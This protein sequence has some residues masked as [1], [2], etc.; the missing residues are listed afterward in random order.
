MT[1]SLIAVGLACT[2]ASPVASQEIVG[3]D[4]SSF[5]ISEAV[6]Q[7]G[8]VRIA[9]PNGF[10]RVS[11]GSGTRVEIR[12]EKDVRRGSVTDVG[13]VVRREGNG[14][15]V[16]AVYEGVDECDE[17]GSYRGTSASRASSHNRQ[18]R[19][20]FTVQMPSGSRVRASTGNG[21][22]QVTGGGPEVIAASGNGAITVSGAA[23]E[24][25]ASSGNGKVT[26][27][28]AGGPVEV[29]SGNGDIRVNTILGPVSANSGNGTIEV[30][31]DRLT[32]SPDMKFSTGNGRIILSVPDD[33][34]AE[35][36]S[37]TGNGR[38]SVD[39]PILMQGRINPSRVRGTIGDGGGRLVMSSGNGNLEI[40][41]HQ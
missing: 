10:V 39:F 41:R 20:N 21:E 24:V 4:G 25:H 19:V 32:G 34:G 23:G 17:D 15:T 16:C 33:F 12:A 6:A 38:V 35:L 3:R 37:N 8:W 18:I 2:L 31:I 40:R 9:S 7:G 22:V 13:F 30:S 29:S 14:V 27:D 36:E 26:V 28:G 11:E 1:R 5:S